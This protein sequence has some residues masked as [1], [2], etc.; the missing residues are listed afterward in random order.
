M[1]RKRNHLIKKKWVD[2]NENMDKGGID[3]EGGESERERAREGKKNKEINVQGKRLDDFLLSAYPDVCP[4][5]SSIKKAI[6][7]GSSAQQKAGSPWDPSRNPAGS[8]AHVGFN[9][10]SVTCFRSGSLWD[11]SGSP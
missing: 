2:I 5:I 10:Y 8:P 7:K 11:P 3:K 1:I 6:R 4:S 9:A